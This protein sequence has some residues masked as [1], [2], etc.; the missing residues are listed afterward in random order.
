MDCQTCH[1]GVKAYPHTAPVPKAS[2]DTC[3]DG[4]VKEFEAGAHAALRHA[5]NTKAP[6]CASCHNDVH[7]TRKAKDAAFRQ[8]VPKVCGTCHTEISKQ[9]QASVHG[10]LVLQGDQASA[11][12]TSC[13]G[14]HTN[15]PPRDPESLVSAR[16]IRQTCASCHEN[17]VLARRFHLPLDKVTTFDQSFHGLAAKT[18]TQ[19]VA[20][21]ASC[22]GIHNILPAADPKS[23]INPANLKTTC[24]HCHPGASERFANAKM[25]RTEK[26]GQPTA[27]LIIRAIYLILI[28]ATITLMFL[29][30]FGDFVRKARLLRQPGA[31]FGPPLVELRMH[32]AERLIHGLMAMSFIV[33]V[34]SGFALRYPDSWW[35]EPMVQF[36]ANWPVRGTLHRAAAI[37]ILIAG[38]AHI[39]GLLASRQL[40]AHWLSLVPRWSDV[41]QGWGTFLYNLGLRKTKPELPHHSYVAKVEYWA[42]VWGTVIMALTGFLLWANKYTF[43]WIPREWLDA[44]AALHFYEA[45]LATFAVLV[46]HFYTVIFDPEVYPIDPAFLTGKSNRREITVAEEAKKESEENG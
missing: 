7:E 36:E 27:V 29:H 46:W 11:S 5:G 28:P 37:A 8:D 42:V 25:H 41:P 35:A 40:R 24:G 21:C 23:T 22:H 4:A 16:N 43:Q 9:Y 31:A 26:E 33:L 30:H 20:N 32:G 12:C 6:T 17:V 15:L 45:V 39:A 13:H 19:T 38:A 10:A 14:A 2:C 18:G 3:H 1:E 44:A 34:L